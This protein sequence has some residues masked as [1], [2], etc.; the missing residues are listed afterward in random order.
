MAGHAPRTAHLAADS[1]GVR[2]AGAGVDSGNVI[3]WVITIEFEVDL[4]L[5]FRGL[6]IKLEGQQTCLEHSTCR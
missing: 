3:Q 1:G 4:S 6:R 2:G 5:G